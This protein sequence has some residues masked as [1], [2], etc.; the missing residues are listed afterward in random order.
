MPLGQGQQQAFDARQGGSAVLQF[1][2]AR[3]GALFF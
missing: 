3:Q 1:S 2:H